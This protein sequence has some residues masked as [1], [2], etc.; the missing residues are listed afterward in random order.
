MTVMYGYVRVKL[1]SRAHSLL[2]SMPLRISL[3]FGAVGLLPDFDHL[4][5]YWA[6]VRAAHPALLIGSSIV[7][8]YYLTCI[9]RLT[10]GKVLEGDK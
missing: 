7:L 1:W 4:M 10:V 8:C 9:G 2:Y 3:I 6:G 5:P